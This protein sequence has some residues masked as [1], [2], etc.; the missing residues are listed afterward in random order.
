MPNAFDEMKKLK[1]GEYTSAHLS[2]PS[3][4]KKA[5]NYKKVSNLVLIFLGAFLFFIFC[6]FSAMEITKTPQTVQKHTQTKTAAP[7]L[8]VIK[9]NVCPVD[10]MG[11]PGVCGIVKNNSSRF[12]SYAQININLYDQRHN[13]IGTAMDN[14]NNIPVNGTWQ[15][16]AVP[17][18]YPTPIFYS[19][20]IIS[21]TGW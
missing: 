18:R 17:L 14:I 13:L 15:F 8:Q 3:Y 16:I 4:Y 12:L 19:Y 5:D 2:Q 10:M 11:T 20:E 1:N 7:M 9:T 21:V 6:K